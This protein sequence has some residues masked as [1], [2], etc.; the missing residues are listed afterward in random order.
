[1]RRAGAHLHDLSP[2]PNHPDWFT[3]AWSDDG[4]KTV[5][6]MLVTLRI[7]RE[8]MPYLSAPWIAAK[9]RQARCEYEEPE[10][11]PFSQR[12]RIVRRP[13]PVAQEPRRNSRFESGNASNG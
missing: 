13:T 2:D 8:R 12:R 3:T 9:L 4:G 7:V 5:I 6:Y 10:P 1:M 11:H